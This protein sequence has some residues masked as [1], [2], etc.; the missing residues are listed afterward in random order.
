MNDIERLECAWTPLLNGDTLTFADGSRYTFY[1]I[2]NQRDLDEIIV[3]ENS[4]VL[5]LRK[6]LLDEDERPQG[7]VS[8]LSKETNFDAIDHSHDNEE[9]LSDEEEMEDDDEIRPESSVL[10]DKLIPGLIPYDK[11]VDMM[12]RGV[13]GT[14]GDNVEASDSSEEKEPKDAK[15]IQ[16]ELLDNVNTL[17]SMIGAAVKDEDSFVHRVNEKENPF[18]DGEGSLVQMKRPTERRLID[19]LLTDRRKSLPSLDLN[20]PLTSSNVF[21]LIPSRRG[22][23]KRREKHVIRLESS[24]RMSGNAGDYEDRTFIMYRSK[25]KLMPS[26]CD[27]YD[28]SIGVDYSW[29]MNDSYDYVSFIL[30]LLT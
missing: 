12:F 11:R 5:Y 30:C 16:K 21:S 23:E 1:N 28:V 15:A 6:N 19:V 7:F 13:I 14:A 17:N 3:D 20:E 4:I 25:N 29:R 8:V 26:T 9:V 10:V 22:N 27:V 18:D 2:Y 24:N